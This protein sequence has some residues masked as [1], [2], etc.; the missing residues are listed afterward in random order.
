[1]MLRTRQIA[2]LV[3]SLLALGCWGWP[4]NAQ[5]PAPDLRGTWSGSGAEGAIFG[6]LGHQPPREQP[7]FSDKSIVWT[8]KIDKQ[9]GR[10]LIGTWS[11][12]KYS[13]RLLGVVRQDNETVLFSDEDSYFQAKI[14]S[15]TSMEVCVQETGGSIV[16][17][18]RI[19]DKQ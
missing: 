18:C 17:T 13:E 9:D 4:A 6:Q 7:A 11:T 15:P 19:L 14:L 12:P 8:V 10:G 5:S 2:I 16:A 3:V 1:M